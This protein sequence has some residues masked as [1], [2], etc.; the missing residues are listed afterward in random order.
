MVKATGIGVNVSFIINIMN[1]SRN[2]FLRDN[3]LGLWEAVRHKLKVTLKSE[4]FELCD[5]EGLDV[6]RQMTIPEHKEPMCLD[7]DS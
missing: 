6:F 1:R 5:G 7:M 2:T 4:K 3:S